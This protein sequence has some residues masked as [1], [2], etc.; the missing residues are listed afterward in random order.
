M[1]WLQDYV[2]ELLALLVDPRKRVS[3]TYLASAALIALVWGTF[4][5]S[6]FKKGIHRGFSQLFSK[7]IWLSRSSV[8]D[9]Q[10][11][12]ANHAVM[13]TLMPW[14][15]SRLALTTAIF[16]WLHEVFESRPALGG[17]TPLWLVMSA[18]TAT[19]FLLDDAT[20][21]LVHRL[22]HRVPV[23]WAFHSV[24]HTAETLTPLTVY[25][26]HP[27]EGVL[28]SVQRTGCQAVVIAGF[29]F[30]FGNNVSLVSVLGANV[31]LFAFNVFGANLRHSHVPITYGSRIERWLISPLQH[32]LHHSRAHRHHDCNFGAVLALWDNLGGTLRLAEGESRLRFGL[33]AGGD[34]G[35][36]DLK[37]FYL[38]PFKT[39]Y[40]RM[41]DYLACEGEIRGKP[42]APLGVRTSVFCRLVLLVAAL[43]ALVCFTRTGHAEALNIYSHRQ[44]FLIEPFIEAFEAKTGV[45]VNVVY[46]SKGL[47]QRLQAE[48]ERSPADVVLTVDIGRLWVYA[49]KEL[50]APVES[51]ILK[52]NIPAHLRDPDNHWFAFSRR[53]RVIAYSKSRVDTA[54]ISRIEDLA[55]PRWEGRIC[56][57]PGSHVYNRALLSS[58]VAANGEEAA[59]VWARGLVGNLAQRPQGNDRA[60][61]KAIHEG[62]CD[63]ALVNSY[64]FGKVKNSDIF[65]QRQ[66]V[67]D[68][69]ILFTNQADRGNHINISGGGV[70]R[71]SKNKAAAV[72]FLE[73][74][75]GAEAQVLY[76]EINYEFPV[77]PGVVAGEEVSS[78]G[79]FEAD[80]LPIG[81]I[82]ELAPTAQRIIDRAGW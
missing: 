20:R 16:F 7:K 79:N 76:T 29:V 59:E 60:Q 37:A 33:G 78:W 46:S 21:Y 6:S 64:Y 74:L 69:G 67:S 22:L 12:L 51:E 72:K 5:S 57:R 25:R 9:Y 28:F 41:R 68:I 81:R 54:N 38:G 1:D 45:A 75:T 11:F 62:V 26:T 43:G 19:L 61:I 66:W 42:A 65:E 44:P 52:T 13:M 23:L 58:I 47:A 2:R 15:L 32:Q 77:K 4:T 56:S 50:L 14:L 27:V 3:V 55:D 18:F 39:I 48:G 8:G 53:A 82:A 31:F 70:A 10:L 36:H 80:R 63:L 35:E 17:H 49:D 73:F 30:F 34:E 71:Y 40:R 24:H